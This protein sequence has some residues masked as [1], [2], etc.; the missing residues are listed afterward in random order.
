MPHRT[1]FPDTADSRTVLAS[2]LVHWPWDKIAAH[3]FASKVKINH[4]N[5]CWEWQGV[6]LRGYGQCSIRNPS[7]KRFD[8]KQAH[9]ISYIGTCGDIKD[10]LTI[11]HLCRNRGCVNPSHL[12]PVTRTE[13]VLRGDSVTAINKR[14][15][16]CIRGHEFSRIR[17]S[18]YRECSICKVDVARARRAELK[19]SRAAELERL[20]ATITA[21][22]DRVRRME[23]AIS[24]ALPMLKKLEG[25]GYG[26]MSDFD[27][28]VG[29]LEMSLRPHASTEGGS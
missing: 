25:Q 12:E 6:K 3:R 14:K 13:N 29:L 22:L 18:G 28:P 10:D 27:A 19:K 1:N 16:H 7:G 8:T 26:G 24:T 9:R 15:T 2:I 4:G 17:P 21:L 20:N 23:E 5:G 11:D